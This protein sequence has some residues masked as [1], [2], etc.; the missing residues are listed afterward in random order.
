MSNPKTLRD[1]SFSEA[2][3][4]PKYWW[5]T[6]SHYLG[7]APASFEYDGMN[8]AFN[9]AHEAAG[10]GP[11]TLAST[12]RQLCLRTR[13]NFDRLFTKGGTVYQDAADAQ[14]KITCSRALRALRS[15]GV[16]YVSY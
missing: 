7:P 5:E 2:T 15:R 3:A 14:M 4:G 6:D 16:S 10:A 9:R 8:R 1:T 13:A 11:E 12:N